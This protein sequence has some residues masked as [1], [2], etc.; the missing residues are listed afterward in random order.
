VPRIDRR[1]GRRLFGADPAAYDRAR[2]GHP[3]GVYGFLVERCGLEPGKAVLEVGP[4]TG[5]ATR[6]LLE[7]GANPLVAVEPDPAL[8]AYLNEALGARI[9]LRVVALE[10]AALPPGSFDLAAAAS[11]F[12]WIEEALGLGRA[13]EALR[14]GGWFAMWWTLFGDESRP[15]PDPF[16]DAIDPIVGELPS[17]PSEGRWGR[18]RFALD[19]DARA[20]AL[21]AAGFEQYEHELIR[22]SFE[23]NTAGIRALFATFSPIARLQEPRREAVLDAVANVAADEFGGHVTKPLLTSLY[24]ARRPD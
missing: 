11:S 8:A 19:I 1:E 3:D 7:L 15:I 9:E 21:R 13:F 4:G 10:D 24:T 12:H 22:W 2:P 6:R 23:W 16:R 5:Q 14:P 20:A 18:P 17:S